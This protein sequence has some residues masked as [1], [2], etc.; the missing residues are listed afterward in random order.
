MYTQ[1]TT[2]LKG[3]SLIKIIKKNELNIDPCGTPT[4]TG[5]ASEMFPLY[6]NT[7]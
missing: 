3:K 2:T 6:S 1:K 4:S 5:K 7:F